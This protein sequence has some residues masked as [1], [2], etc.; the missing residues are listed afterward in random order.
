MA[1]FAAAWTWPLLI[2]G[3]QV[4]TYRVGMAVPDWPTTF[5]INMFLY[6]FWNSSW[7]VFI[8]HRHRLFGSALG[9]TAIVL[10]V[11]LA[12]SDPRRWMKV[13]GS[14]ALLAVIVQGVI[15]GQRV[16]LNSTTWAAVHACTG[17]AVFALFVTLAVLTG[18]SWLSDP[19]PSPDTD[20]IRRRSVVMLALVGGQIAVGA[21]LRHFGSVTALVVHAF[22]ATAVWG[23]ALALSYRV[24]R[25]GRRMLALIPSGRALALTTTLQVGLGVAAWWMLRPFDGL[26]RPVSMSQALIRTGHQAQGA[27]V[28][29]AVVVLT[30]RSFRHLGPVV[31]ESIRPAPAVLDLE[32]V[33]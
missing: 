8:E 28:L 13:L 18:R 19:V 32:A 11:W 27:L 16:L 1:V 26:P 2:S 17:Q 9:F 7:G 20:H 3:G 23:H 6:D 4:T 10:A 21:W 15:G 12:V 22:L 25:G 31:R 33:A 24:G 29:A 14:L 5:G 30:L